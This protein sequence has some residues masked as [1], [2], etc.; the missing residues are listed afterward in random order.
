M[1]DASKKLT[2]IFKPF[3][4]RIA[5][6]FGSRAQEV[7]EYLTATMRMETT[8]LSDID[9]GIKASDDPLLSVHSK[10]RLALALEDLLGVQRVDLVSLDEADPFLAANIV[11]GE[12][13]FCED[14]YLAD[15]YELYVLRRAGDLAPF[16]RHR[17]DEILAQNP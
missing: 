3:H 15:E 5:Y 9:I 14:P 17:I 12:R 11:R 10:V 4:V 16:E 2:E 7:K 6:A 1:T 8:S 13:I